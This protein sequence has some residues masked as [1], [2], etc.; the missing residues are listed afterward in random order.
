MKRNLL[1]LVKRRLNKLLNN[2]SVIRHPF[3]I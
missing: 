3:F 2:S 1:V